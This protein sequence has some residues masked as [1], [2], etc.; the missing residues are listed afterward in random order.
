MGHW[1]CIWL[2]AAGGLTQSALTAVITA[3]PV[4]YTLAECPPENLI[5]NLPESLVE[6][7]LESLLG[8]TLHWKE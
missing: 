7:Q 6:S 1:N 5:E 4:Q 8:S 3:I 2:A